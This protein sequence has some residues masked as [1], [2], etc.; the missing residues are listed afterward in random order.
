MAKTVTNVNDPAIQTLIDN[1]IYTCTE[2]GGVGIAAPQVGHSLNIFI[3]ASKPNDCYPDAPIM[4]PTAIINPVIT[5]D[6][7]ETEDGWEGC[8]SIP[9]IR[10]IVTRHKSVTVSFT[11]RN[12]VREERRFDGFV[13][14]VFQH[15][16]D[17]LIG[18]VFLDR[19]NTSTFVT[20]KEYRRILKKR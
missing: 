13:A 20:D 16:Y 9:G 7:G 17:H 5:S 8:L 2:S 11:N 19:A 14:R 6:T 15:E 10:G 18:T 1:M 4:E 12:G 3:I